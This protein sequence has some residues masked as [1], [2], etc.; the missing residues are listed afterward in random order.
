MFSMFSEGE[1]TQFPQNG[2]MSR[3]KFSSFTN[4]GRCVP[5]VAEIQSTSM[6]VAP[7]FDPPMWL[8]VARDVNIVNLNKLI[9]LIINCE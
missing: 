7:S 6:V 2:F 5:A 8:K 4:D 3:T 9:Q 1:E